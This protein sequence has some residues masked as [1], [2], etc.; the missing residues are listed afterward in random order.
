M[1]YICTTCKKEFIG[2]KNP[3]A[4]YCSIE[5]MGKGRVGIKFSSEHKKKL[6][7]IAKLRVGNKSTRYGSKMPIWLKEKLRR[8]NIGRS[9]WNKGLNKYK[10]PS[11]MEVS[12]TLTG[13]THTTTMKGKNHWNWKG[14]ISNCIDCGKLL[15]AHSVKRCIKC[16]AKYQSGERRYN[17]KGGISYRNENVRIR[18][19][20]QIRLWRNAVYARD[21][22]TCQECGKT[23]TELN[24][25]HIKPFS[26]HPGLR[27]AI[28]NGITL[29]KKCHSK[30]H[31]N[32][33]IFDYGK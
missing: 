30:K 9:P 26:S 12:K 1:K 32:K 6:S 13:R 25:H 23:S 19:S 2:R 3:K 5:C 31:F 27:F 22:F 15:S 16:Q 24:A 17:W 21:S 20:I 11:I 14:G 7:E 10:H 28:D 4:K 33:K 29:C 8:A 18:G